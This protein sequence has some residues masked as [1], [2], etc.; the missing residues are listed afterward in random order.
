MG[1]RC[2]VL[3]AGFSKAVADLPVTREFLNRFEEL[4]DEQDKLGNKHRARWGREVVDFIQSAVNDFL[5]EP[6]S[7]WNARSGESRQPV[8]VGWSNY[9]ENF[10]A[11]CSFLDF[12]LQAELHALV[13]SGNSESDFSGKPLFAN[14]SLGKLQNIREYLSEY[15]Y[16]A[17]IA[18]EADKD[19]M[20]NFYNHFLSDASSVVTFNYDLVLERFLFQKGVWFPLNGY[21]FKP[22]TVPQIRGEF[23]SAQSKVGI[24]KMHG[25]LS[26]QPAPD[27]S[28]GTEFGW[29]DDSDR[30]FF[31][32]YLSKDSGRGFEYV[33]AHNHE[34]WILPSW[35]KQFK[36]RDL[37]AVWSQAA[38]SLRNSDEIIFVGYS[39]PEEDS[40]V[41][42]F[43][44][45]IDFSKK[46]IVVFDPTREHNQLLRRFSNAL[47]RQSKEISLFSCKLEEYLESKC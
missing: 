36:Y 43:L 15:V 44:S 7:E 12:S 47:R 9:F 20:E 17:L 6:Y 1:G 4:I 37:I 5:V 46:R 27:G 28:G 26:W 21:G 18:G 10:E 16:L 11:L 34:R 13:T 2:L 8:K 3:G 25:S 23:A 41:C 32:E 19:R 29:H 24:L 45:A 38:E 30:P 14:Y 40:T 22:W 42:S 31:P 33:G 39:L 35:I